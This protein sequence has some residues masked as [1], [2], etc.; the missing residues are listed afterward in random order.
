ML[1]ELLLL[2]AILPTVPAAPETAAP[3]ALESHNLEAKPIQWTGNVNIGASYSD[4]NTDS[5]AINAA[6]TRFRARSFSRMV[7]M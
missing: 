2:T 7:V 3:L 6:S 1:F 5:R 4:G